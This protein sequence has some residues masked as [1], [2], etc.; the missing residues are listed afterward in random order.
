[1]KLPGYFDYLDDPALKRHLRNAW[2]LVLE[3]L[4][5]SEDKK[6]QDRDELLSG[7]RK[8]VLI[9]TAAIVEAL[10]LW[11]LKKVINDGDVVLEDEWKYKDPRQIHVFEDGIEIVWAH[12]ERVTKRID[13]LD[14]LHI[15][16][17]CQKHSL[18][19]GE[20]LISDVNKLRAIRNRLH[21]GNLG[22]LEDNYDAKD[23]E[24]GF[25]VLA[26]VSKQVESTRIPNS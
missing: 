3:L 26:R 9:H 21:V 10:L 7:L 5:M 6:Y 15:S 13:R 20:K 4:F 8:T 14:F 17:E 2:E 24:F 18:L 22:D 1:M 19:R 11:K 12:R 23:A 16:R 25:S